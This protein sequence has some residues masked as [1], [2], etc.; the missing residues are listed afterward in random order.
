M[1]QHF[2]NH[3]VLVS[4]WDVLDYISNAGRLGA[5]HV[6]DELRHLDEGLAAGV[7]DPLVPARILIRLTGR[8]GDNEVYPI[9]EGVQGDRVD[10]VGIEG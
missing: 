5:I 4:T 10:A 7:F 2:L 6:L 3:G 1:S 9:G 8:T